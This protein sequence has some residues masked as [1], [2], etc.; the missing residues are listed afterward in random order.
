MCG[1]HVHFES[2]AACPGADPKLHGAGRQP[3]S[4]APDEQGALQ[5]VSAT[6]EQ[7]GPLQ[8]P[9]AQRRH[10]MAADG[11]DPRL[12]ALADD[13]GRAVRQVDVA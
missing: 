7:S 2:L 6:P 9:V 12:G 5:G 8:E 10:R 13:A 11:H 4:A 1:M 3:P